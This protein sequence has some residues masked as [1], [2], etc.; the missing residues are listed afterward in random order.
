[1]KLPQKQGSPV[2]VIPDK[3]VLCYIS[4]WRHGHTLIL[5]LVT[6]VKV[7]LHSN[8]AVT[9]RLKF[10][11]HPNCCPFS[12]YFSP[13]VPPQCPHTIS[14]ERVEEYPSECASTKTHQVFVGLVHLLPLRPGKTPE[15]GYQISQTGKPL[16][17]ASAPLTYNR[18]CNTVLNLVRFI[19]LH[20]ATHP[21]EQCS[22]L[23][24]LCSALSSSFF[25]AYH[26]NTG[27][28]SNINVA[29]SFRSWGII[30]F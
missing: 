14:S 19:Y 23:M 17:I 18:V 16:G 4:T 30:L 7:S 5:L 21:E 8:R 6:L 9:D 12:C 26:C 24:L 27:E 13:T 29:R 15:L 10:T 11:L 20:L 22:G 3:L 28:A 25:C 1:M 2:P